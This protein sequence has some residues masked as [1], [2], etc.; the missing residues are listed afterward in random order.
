MLQA[1]SSGADERAGRGGT[2]GAFGVGEYDRLG[3]D[4]GGSEDAIRE[5]FEVVVM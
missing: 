1:C 5:K 2:A 3:G 4:R